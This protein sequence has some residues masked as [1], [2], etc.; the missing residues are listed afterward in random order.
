MSTPYGNDPQQW[1][2]QPQ[3]GQQPGGAYP[4]SGPQ[5][6]P[7][8]GQ[9]QQPP[10]Q[11]QWGQQPPDYGQQPQP[12]YG[13]PQQPYGQPGQQPYGQPQDPGQQQYG[14]QPGAY[15]QTGPQPQ[16]Q[17]G[18]QPGMPGQY[19]YGQPPG[20][21]GGAQEGA[22]GGKSKKGLWIGVGALILVV[23]V[24]AVLGFLAPGFFNTKV[25]DN[26]KMQTDVQKILTDN[27]Q[28]EGASNVTCPA[29]QAVKDGTTFTCTVTVA[30]KQQTVPIKVV[31]DSGDYQVGAPAGQ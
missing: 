31:G 17:Y 16:Q 24:V 4:P 9:P 18:Q 28:V 29:D 30:G 14:Q 27:Y 10:Q 7:G 1:G 3:Y 20:Y 15:P 19:D 11:P 12:G 5:P 22:S 26:A 8:Y 13:Q 2:Q 6:Q 23:A 21:P 25:F